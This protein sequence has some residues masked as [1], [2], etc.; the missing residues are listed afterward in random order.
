[1][2]AGDILKYGHETVLQNVEGLPE[3]DWLVPRVCGVW[4]VK[5]IVAHLAWTERLILDALTT[6]AGGGPTPYLDAFRRKDPGLNDQEVARRRDWPGKQT[7]AE[8]VEAAGRVMD[9][10]ARIPPETFRRAGN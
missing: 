2:N 4:S 1:M 6:F 9:V 8:Y 10:A 5:D 3:A 7:L